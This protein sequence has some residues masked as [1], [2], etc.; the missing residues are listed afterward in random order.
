M[1]CIP[2]GPAVIGSDETRR[3]KPR[4]E[5]TLSAFYIDR[6]EVTNADYEACVKA[7]GCPVRIPPEPKFNQPQQ[8]AVPL[9]WKMAHAYCRW[10]GKRMPTEAEWEKAARGGDEG[11]RYPW[12]DEEPTCERTQTVGCKPG[13]TLPVGSLPAGAYGIFDMAGNGYE[14]VQDWASECYAGCSKACG[15]ACTGEDPLGPCGGGS[16]CPGHKQR[17]LKGGSW[18]WPADQARGAWRRPSKM[19]SGQHRLS[20]RCAS[21]SPALATWPAAVIADPPGVPPSLSPPSEAQVTTSHDIPEDTDVLQ[22]KPCEKVN[23]ATLKCRDPHSYVLSNEPQR[24]RFAAYIR[25][26]GGGYVGIGADQT[27][28]FIAVQKPRWAW[29]FDYDPS[30]VRLHYA[31]RAQILESDTPAAFVE[32]F[33]PDRIDA[34]VKRTAK[35]LQ[36]DFSSGRLPRSEMGHI[37]RMLKQVMGYLHHAYDEAMKPDPSQG[38]FGWLRHPEHFTYIKRMYAQRRIVL[39]KGNLLTPVVLPAVAKQARALGVPIRVLYTSNADDQWPL[40]AGYMA[41]LAGLPFDARSVVL[42]TI[43]PRHKAGFKKAPWDYTV[44]AA[45]DMQ[46]YARRRSLE[47]WWWLQGEGRRHDP[48]NVVTIALPGR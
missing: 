12:G 43:Y 39:R 30:V 16:D 40:T 31:I 21:S 47:W 14:W 33:H 24:F 26:L 42:R 34:L 19:D 48:G 25:N 38:E 41:N 20:V 5:V 18:F 28:D 13:T 37:R 11:R 32:A 27:Y 8:P 2:A 1:V 4:H 10:A 46:R 44:H 7:K 36:G 9:S 22:I 15:E 29:V 23:V 45:L 17:V 6:H 35:S 3:E